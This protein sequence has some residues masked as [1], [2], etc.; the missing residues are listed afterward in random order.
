MRSRVP[1]GVL[2]CAGA[3][4][5]EVAEGGAGIEQRVGAAASIC[6]EEGDVVAG[7]PAP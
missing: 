2:G 6:E 5:L 3:D 7:L 1:G 4:L